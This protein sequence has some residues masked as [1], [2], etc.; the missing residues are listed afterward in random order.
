MTNITSITDKRIEEKIT[1][2]SSND[3]VTPSELL[4]FVKNKLDSGELN[5]AKC[6]ILT[7]NEDG[8]DLYRFT[9]NAD[10]PT[11]YYILNVAA[12]DIMLKSGIG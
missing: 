11:A 12:T 2:N 9:A 7:V 4:G 6:I 3:E 10:L 1:N 8:T 5:F